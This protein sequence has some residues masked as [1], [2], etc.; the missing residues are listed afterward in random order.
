MTNV[1]YVDKYALYGVASPLFRALSLAGVS[2][3]ATSL[4]E[5]SLSLSLASA[6][7]ISLKNVEKYGSSKESLYHRKVK[8]NG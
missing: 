8:I 4:L 2:Q 6:P 5:I 3:K 7:H 1:H